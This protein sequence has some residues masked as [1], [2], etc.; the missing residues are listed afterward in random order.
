MS[1]IE[2]ILVNDNS[3]DNTSLIIQKLAEDE[4]RI[5]I[6]NNKKNMATLYSRNIGILNSKGKY[7]MN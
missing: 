4:Q 1:D 5:I 7:I 2:I 3:N 6:L